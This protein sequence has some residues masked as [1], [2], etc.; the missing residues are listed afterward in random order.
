LSAPAPARGGM[1][2][3]R[4]ESIHEPSRSLGVP[5]AGDGAARRP[6]G[7]GIPAIWAWGACSGCLAAL[8]L[9]SF[10]RHIAHRMTIS[11]LS[12]V[13]KRMTICGRLK[14]PAY[15]PE[16][17]AMRCC[18]PG[19]AVVKPAKPI[20]ERSH[21]SR[22]PS[23]DPIPNLPPF[24]EENVQVWPFMHGVYQRA[25][26]H[27]THGSNINGRVAPVGLVLVDWWESRSRKIGGRPGR[28]L[29]AALPTARRVRVAST[30]SSGRRV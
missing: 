18:R 1:P 25:P 15:L 24:H 21:E 17:P 27:P 7:C 9:A 13:Q 22:A 19:P 30:G 3:A 4:R 12:F 29:M 16:K 23:R 26:R 14:W 5:A 6:R 10:S 11:L 8:R 20:C 28:R 2:I